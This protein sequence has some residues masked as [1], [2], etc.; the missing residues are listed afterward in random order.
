MRRAAQ[1]VGG[2]GSWSTTV[3]GVEPD[4]LAIKQWD[5]E[6]ATSSP[7]GELQARQ[8]GP[9]RHDRGGE[10]FR[11]RRPDRPAHTGRHRRPFTVI[12]VLESKGERGMGNDQDD[13]V[14]VPLDTALTPDAEQQHLLDRDERGPG[15]PDGAGPG[16]GEQIL[17]EAHRLRRATRMTSTS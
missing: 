1:V 5:V 6:P 7:R 16:R 10:A 15:R 17:R 11:R 8:G 3:Y 12:G 9:A 4:Y 13:V 2:D 14:M